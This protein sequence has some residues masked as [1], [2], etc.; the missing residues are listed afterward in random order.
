MHKFKWRFWSRASQGPGSAEQSNKRNES[1]IKPPETVGV[2]EAC[3]FHF[4]YRLIHN[5]F[6]DSAYA[7]C[8]SCGRTVVLDGWSE[9]ARRV[10]FRIHQQIE[11][12]IEP[13]LKTCPCGG[14]FSH[15]AS[16]R[17]PSCNQELSAEQATDYIERNALGTAG[18]W[19]WQRSWDGVYCIA[20]EGRALSN[21]WDESKLEPPHA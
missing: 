3:G 7:Y 17:C 6:N 16:P 15:S 13:L 21:W 20:I 4:H 9:A 10:R 19:R 11:E 18:G 8:E 1:T 2:C 12:A 14:R 5:G